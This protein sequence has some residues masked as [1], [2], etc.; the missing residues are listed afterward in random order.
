MTNQTSN[1]RRRRRW[2]TALLAAGATAATVASAVP[3]AAATPTGGCRLEASLSFSEF[4][5]DVVGSREWVCGNDTQP[6]TV[7]LK[8]NGVLVASG[9]GIV[10]YHCVGTDPGRFVLFYVGALTAACT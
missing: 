10:T 7:V 5:R 6:L 1:T 9:K 4:A 8:R 2:L 3:A